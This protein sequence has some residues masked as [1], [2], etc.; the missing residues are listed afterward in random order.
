MVDYTVGDRVVCI[1]N[2]NDPSLGPKPGKDPAKEL[3]VGRVYKVVSMELRNNIPMVH[4]EGVGS[5]NPKYHGYFATRFRKVEPGE[6]NW[7]EETLAK[8]GNKKVN[9]PDTSNA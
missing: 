4:V 7:L 8:Y 2:G 6:K 5:S 9:V 3:V 1:N